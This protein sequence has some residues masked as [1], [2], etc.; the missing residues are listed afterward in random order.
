MDPS[1]LERQVEQLERSG[2]EANPMADLGAANGFA[3]RMTERLASGSEPAP[4][5]VDPLSL[6][7]LLAQGFE[8]GPARRALRVHGNDTQAA[9]EWLLHG[10]P[11]PSTPSADRSAR[12]RALRPHAEVPPRDTCQQ[13]TRSATEPQPIE[14]GVR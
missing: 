2:R 13:R 6:S 12:G 4:C 11:N 5:T 9:M 10:E 7:S 3:E 1:N 8:E 14:L